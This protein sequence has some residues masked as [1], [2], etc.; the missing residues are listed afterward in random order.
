MRIS[1]AHLRRTCPGLPDDDAAVCHLLDDVGIEVKR[2]EAADGDTCATLELLA[3]RGDHRCYVGVAREL[4]GR[5]GGTVVSPD[6]LALTTG[7]SPV[8]LRLETDLCLLY[9]ATALEIP[10]ASAGLPDGPLAP[11]IAAG[12]RPISAPVDATNLSNLELGQP[13]HL[14]DA[15]TIV[16][17]ITIRLA[18]AGE[19]AWPLFAAGP[20]DV[21]EGALVIADDEKIL[22][23]A[24]VIGCEE[25]KVTDSTTRM[26]LESACFDPVSVRRAGR[27]L[28]VH[29]DSSAR[30]ERGSDPSLPLV[31]AGRVAH[32]LVAHAGARV[33]GTTG[34]VGAWRDPA[35]M[36]T[37]DPRRVSAYFHR[38]FTADEIAE[39]LSRTGFGTGL[40]A[41]DTHAPI[42][43][44]DV[45]V[46]PGRL[47]DVHHP[48]DLYEELARSVGYNA[49]PDALPP[50]ARGVLPSP[51]QLRLERVEEVVLG[52]GFYEVIT[53][54]FHG[55]ALQARLG[56]PADSPL[57]RH[58]E[59]RNALDSGFTL[60][61]NCALPQ[62]LEALAG[63]VRFGTHDARLFESTRT[64]HLD[65]AADNGLCAERWVLWALASGG[66]P[67]WRAGRPVDLWALKGMVEEIGAALAAPLSI[68]AGSQA[69]IAACLHP[70][71]VGT[72]WRGDQAVGTLGQVC[73][74]VCR[75]F[76]LKAARPVYLELELDGLEL[77]DRILDYPLP[78]PRPPSVR[79]LAFTLPPRVEAGAVR[80]ALLAAGPEWLEHVAPVDVFEHQEGGRAV[81]T[82]TFELHFRN[83][84]SEHSAA[85]LNATTAALID[86]VVASEAAP[87]VTLRA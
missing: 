53:D 80:V 41:L 75:A 50:G 68:S 85:E 69:P 28:G 39:R 1:L 56:L 19:R 14:F 46:P 9:T 2:T 12:L 26:I 58:V 83:D 79:S 47:W 64:F 86:A 48:Q 67:G 76:G 70:L 6:V 34:A 3:N 16:G 61:K 21:P 43:V 84:R 29:T 55:R 27:R 65:P 31:G 22:A 54:G 13:T 38:S 5:L 32:L 71:R 74:P 17:G 42:D 62:A 23:I 73:E 66:T 8:R 30:F 4:V 63:N 10:D 87:G 18:L 52:H 81:R 33:V 51:D 77:R 15:D 11:L 20:C 60:L 37:V 45:Q 7:P 25:S 36:I 78:P 72:V 35:R 59:C 82:V 24:G 40:A 57:S 49:L 44:V